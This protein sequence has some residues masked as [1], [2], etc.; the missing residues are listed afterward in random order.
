M[1]R[2]ILRALR[3]GGLALCLASTATAATGAFDS[4]LTWTAALLGGV[5]AYLARIVAPEPARPALLVAARRTEL[6][7]IRGMKGQRETLDRAA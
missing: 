3:I 4:A 2:F 5:L 7:M 6:S 1:S